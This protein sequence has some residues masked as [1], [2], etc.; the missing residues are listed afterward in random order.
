MLVAHYLHQLLVK[1]KQIKNYST[2]FSVYEA[3][4]IIRGLLS[5]N[6]DQKFIVNYRIN[7]NLKYFINGKNVKFYSAKGTA[8]PDHVIRVKPFPLVIT[9]KKNSTIEEWWMKMADERWKMKDET[10]T[11]DDKWR[12]LKDEWWKIN[13]ECWVMNDEW[14]KMNGRMTKDEW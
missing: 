12:M 2:N 6:K 14:G 9:P 7:Q 13:D 8:T 4:P 11:M 5:E 1:I 3:A 10:W